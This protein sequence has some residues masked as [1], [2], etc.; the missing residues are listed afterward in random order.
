MKLLKLQSVTEQVAAHLREEILRGGLVGDM[1][2]AK[3]LAANL[4]INHKTVDA[5]ALLLEREGFL[6]TQGP[7]KPRR[8]V[9]PDDAPPSALRVAI[10][11]YEPEDAKVHFIIDL[12]HHLAEAGHSCTL[13]AKSLSEMKMDTKRVARLVKKTKA[14][15]WIVQ[16]GPHEVLAWFEKQPFP[17]F[18]LYGRLHTSQLA[19]AGVNKAPAIVKAVERL[20]ALGHCRISMLTRQERRTPSPAF[21]QQTFLDELEARGIPTGNYNLPNWDDTPEGLLRG[22]NTLFQFTPPTA[23]I[24]SDV[25][26]FFATQVHLT[27]RGIPV[28]E[29]VSLI[30][31]DHDSKFEWCRPTIAHI[32]WDYRPVVRQVISWANNVGRG[33][34]DRRKKLAKAEFVEGGTVGLAPREK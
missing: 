7:G 14:D 8:V 17:A 29:R 13:A 2:G 32:R 23:L 31:T 24:I 20:T 5:A 3:S 22:L 12:Q 30:C 19:G 9:R 27:R 16:A 28:P 15:A 33:R 4:G 21:L 26:L 34:E 6:D 1:P 18:A 25:A 10:L 11:L